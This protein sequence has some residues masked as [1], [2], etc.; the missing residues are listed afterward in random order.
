MNTTDISFLCLAGGLL[1]R[2]VLLV[3]IAHRF[4]A[5]HPNFGGQNVCTTVFDRRISSLFIFVG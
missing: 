3:A 2:F 4:G 5:L 1:L